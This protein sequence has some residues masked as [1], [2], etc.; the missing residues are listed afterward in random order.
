[1]QKVILVCLI[2]FPIMLRAQEFD[3]QGHRG[4]RGLM[5]ENSLPAFQKALELGVTTLE[6]DVVV[7]MDGQIVVSHDPWCSSEICFTPGGKEILASNEREHN[8]YHL[9]YQ[10]IKAYDCGSKVNTRFTDQKKIVAY[11]PLLVDVFKMA[12]KFCKDE[13]RNEI[14]YNIEIKS[15]P[16]WEGVFH[17]VYQEFCDIVFSTVDA[18]VPWERVTIQSFDF[19]VL[20]YY[21]HQYPEVQLSAL[22]EFEADQEKV[23]EILGFEPEIYSPYYKLLKPKK[24]KWLQEKGIK[25]IPWTVNDVKEMQDLIDMGVDGII[26]DYPDLIQQF[27]MD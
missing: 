21:H 2:F 9:T 8:I 1:M 24:V 27:L 18:Y 16:D 3:W 10:Q 20:Q 23:I 7:S 17:P 25:V 26:T 11:K 14:F 6:M 4:A 19:R 5:P 12:E 22:E 13:M 15:N